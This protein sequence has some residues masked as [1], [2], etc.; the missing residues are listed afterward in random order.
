MVSSGNSPSNQPSK[1]WIRV[2][3][4]HTA[5]LQ[6]FITTPQFNNIAVLGDAAAAFRKRQLSWIVA[7]TFGQRHRLFGGG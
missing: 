1:T 5:D 2:L 3:E 7:I 6:P 4:L